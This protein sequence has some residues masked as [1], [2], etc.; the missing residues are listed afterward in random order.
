MLAQIVEKLNTYL[1]KTFLVACYM[2]CLIFASL[3]LLLA[4][5]EFPAFRDFLLAEYNGLTSTKAVDFA[6]ALIA[7]GIFA[8]AT[9]PLTPL[10]RIVLQGERLPTSV[11]EALLLP[12]ALRRDDLQT[13][14]TA[15][16]NRRNLLPISPD[17]VAANLLAFKE[18][19]IALN[20]ITDS[21]AIRAAER[22]MDELREQRMFNRIIDAGQFNAALSALS[23]ALL[24]NCSDVSSLKPNMETQVTRADWHH[25][26]HLQNLY[27]EMRDTMLPYV[28]DIAERTETRQLEERS[29]RFADIEL[30]PTQLGNDAAALRGYCETRYGLEFDF[31]WPRL[32]LVIQKDQALSDTIVAAKMQLDFWILS[33]GLILLT[34]AAWLGVLAMWG[35]RHS[36]TTLFIVTALTPLLAYGVLN[37]VHASFA[38]FSEA[39]RSAIDT[40]RLD[41]I[42]ALQFPRPTNPAAE[43][44]VWTELTRWIKLNGEPPARDYKA[45]KSAA[46]S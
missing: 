15:L 7:V 35:D 10:L 45:A 5:A 41:L 30:A 13:K 1:G 34:A 25:A 22:A 33:L 44:A 17:E 40:K 8:Y 4:Y 32:L 42:E 3:N 6:V 11:A 26:A 43:Q 36:L 19:G 16:E 21:D 12:Y 9:S 24:R 18:R 29:R 46:G 14:L 20:R 37:L 28:M 38:L 31:F 2:P 39:V 27:M 23:T